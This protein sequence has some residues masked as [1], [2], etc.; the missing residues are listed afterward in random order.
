VEPAGRDAVFDR[1]GAHIRGDQLGAAHDAVL[2]TGERTDDLID[3]KWDGFWAYRPHKASRLAHAPELRAMSATE[4]P[5]S[6]PKL[7]YF[8]A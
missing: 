4:H 3:G 8:S 7:T 5:P 1:V 2:A 6:M